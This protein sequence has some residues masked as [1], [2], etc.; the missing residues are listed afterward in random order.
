MPG[1]NQ[2]ET[3]SQNYRRMGLASKLNHATGGTEKTP[4]RQDADG[5]ALPY[6][7]NAF[8]VNQRRPTTVEIEEIDV[9]RDPK[10]GEI[11]RVNDDGSRKPNPLNDPL[12]DLNDS[13]PED[14]Q[15]FDNAQ[16]SAAMPARTDVVKELEAHAAGGVHKAPRKQSTR[17]QEW[18]EKLVEKHGDDYEKMAWDAKINPMKQTAADIKRRVKKLRQ[19]QNV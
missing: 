13:E 5:D 7:N 17:E 8:A 2:K 9:E 11:I 10:T 12:N 6:E 1:R 3:L 15:G 14:W 16:T 19:G 4:K 18:V